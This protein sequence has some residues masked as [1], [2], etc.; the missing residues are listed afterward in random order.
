MCACTFG[1][2]IFAVVM[3]W[4]TNDGLCCGRRQWL[5]LGTKCWPRRILGIFGTGG[6]T[7][8]TTLCTWLVLF[9]KVLWTGGW[10]IKGACGIRAVRLGAKTEFG[11]GRSFRWAGS[12]LCCCVFGLSVALWCK[13][14]FIAEAGWFVVGKRGRVAF[15]ARGTKLICCREHIRWAKFSLN[16]LVFSGPLDS[17]IW[18]C[19]CGKKIGRIILVYLR[20]NGLL[21]GWWRNHCGVYR[22]RVTICGSF[23]SYARKRRALL[24]CLIYLLP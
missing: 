19:A 21:I 15:G 18:S 13:G 14:T 4:L 2:T 5:I 7:E 6:A 10:L 22:R 9:W 23:V 8:R 12:E 1:A 16:R 24:A 11:K 3:S 17:E 20:S